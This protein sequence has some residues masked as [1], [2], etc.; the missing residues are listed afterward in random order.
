MLFP[1]ILIRGTVRD[2]LDPSCKRMDRTVELSLYHFECKYNDNNII[3]RNMNKT[4][5]FDS[6]LDL[7]L[8]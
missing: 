8:P 4:N 3:N 5:V 6:Y 2:M 7:Y 1:I